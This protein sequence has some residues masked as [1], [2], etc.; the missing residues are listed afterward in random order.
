MSYRALT[1]RSKVEDTITTIR[2]G[3][4]LQYA[5]EILSQLLCLESKELLMLLTKLALY[6]LKYNY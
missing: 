3:M 6:L 1:T 5:E 2:D 4:P